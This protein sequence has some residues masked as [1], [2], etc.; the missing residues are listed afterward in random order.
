[1]HLLKWQRLPVIGTGA[2]VATVPT[3]GGASSDG[4]EPAVKFSPALLSAAGSASIEIYSCPV[5]I[6]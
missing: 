6:W 4:A 1:M 2:V 3:V 5:K